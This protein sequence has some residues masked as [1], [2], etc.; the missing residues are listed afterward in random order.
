MKLLK[1]ALTTVAF[2]GMSSVA[3]A[4]DSNLYANLGVDAVSIDAID[5]D[6]LAAT[7]RVGY[8]INEIFAVEGQASFGLNDDNI[9]RA[10]DLS[11]IVNGV[12]LATVT[13]DASLDTS[14]AAFVKAGTALDNGIEFFGR[15]GYH[16]SSVELSA[17]APGVG[18]ADDDVDLDDLSLIHI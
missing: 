2:A 16:S 7:L 18:S 12:D 9:I 6:V 14:F 8:D 13:V 10:G 3:V 5:A 11:G 4:G 15:L 1:I 17:S